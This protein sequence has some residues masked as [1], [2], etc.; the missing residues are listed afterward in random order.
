[1]F[2]KKNAFVNGYGEPCEII[3]IDI[4]NIWHVPDPLIFRLN[5]LHAL[6]VNPQST[7]GKEET[8][9]PG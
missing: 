5:V 4:N 2:I 8:L 6:P 3:D 9:V 1:M 7:L